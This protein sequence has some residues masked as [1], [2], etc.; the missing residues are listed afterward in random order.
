MGMGVI[1]ISWKK[2]VY[3]SIISLGL[4]KEYEEIWKTRWNYVQDILDGIELKKEN[5][6]INVITYCNVKFYHKVCC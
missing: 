2:K 4:L 1:I 5:L 6:S 3:S